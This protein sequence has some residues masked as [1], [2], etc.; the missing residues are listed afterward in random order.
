VRNVHHL[1]SCTLA[2]DLKLVERVHSV[3]GILKT[4][5][6][7]RYTV[8]EGRPASCDLKDRPT[9]PVGPQIEW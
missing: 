2:G 5:A 8:E 6:G 1:T 9:F 3:F 7:Q 4:K